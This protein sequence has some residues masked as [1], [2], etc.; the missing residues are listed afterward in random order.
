MAKR[1]K[2]TM[3]SI[4]LDALE[5]FIVRAKATT[6]VGS[7][8]PSPSHRPASHDLEFHE[9]P[10]AYLDSYFGGADFWR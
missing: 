1:H 8:M 10:F 7:G 3:Q 2:A 4:P 5:K 9:E 6:Y